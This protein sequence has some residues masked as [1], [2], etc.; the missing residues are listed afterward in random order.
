[1][2]LKKYLL[3]F[4]NSKKRFKPISFFSFWDKETQIDDRIYLGATARLSNSKVGKYTRIKPGCVIKNADI[5]N[6]CSIANDVIIGPGQHP[7]KFI[8]TNSI[9][10][11]PGITD[12]FASDIDF[13]EEPRI[14]IG[15]DVWIGNGALIMDGITIGNGAVIASRAVVTKDVEPYAIVGGVPAKTLKF[16]F[17][18]DVIKALESTKWWLLDDDK[19]KKILPIFTDCDLTADKIKKAFSA[20]I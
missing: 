14:T 9:F 16:R 3:N 15:N 18:D 4:F 10:Y 11:K 19:I 1:M 6:F 17:N 8:S 2:E 13:E 5:G 12:Y 7:T 20:I